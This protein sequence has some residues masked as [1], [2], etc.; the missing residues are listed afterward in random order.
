M[1]NAGLVATLVG[2]LLEEDDIELKVNKTKLHFSI[3]SS[4]RLVYH[5]GHTPLVSTT[6]P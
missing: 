6:I 2:R 5:S 4:V 3:S 1:V